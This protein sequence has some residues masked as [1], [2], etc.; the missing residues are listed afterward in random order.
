ME[1][2]WRKDKDAFV[3][4]AE[5]LCSRTPRKGGTPRSKNQGWW[6]EEVAKA[7][8]EKREA[9]KMIEVIRHRGGQQP[10]GLRHLYGQK[11]EAARRAVD[12]A[13]RCMEE[14]L[15]RK[16]DEGGGKI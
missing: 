7:V 16:L 11:R 10:T 1:G 12:T 8:G 13:R 4:V 6:T 9:R 15:Y 2:E 5:E 14:E 3:G